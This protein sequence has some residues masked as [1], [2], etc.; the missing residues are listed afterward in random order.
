MRR[1]K[2]SLFH[3]PFLRKVR[4]E[5]KEIRQFFFSCV[6]RT[7]V[8]AFVIGSKMKLRAE[9]TT[10]RIV[11]NSILL[12]HRISFSIYSL[13]H[14]NNNNITPDGKPKYVPNLHLSHC[15][16]TSIPHNQQ[17]TTKATHRNHNG[18]RRTGWHRIRLTVS[19]NT[20]H[21]SQNL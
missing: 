9:L 19:K 2:E 7:D 13:H 20:F 5:R 14:P 17:R 12:I 11:L 15:V 3:F 4:G 16:P 21:Y 18:E 10:V 1:E 6:A 8:K